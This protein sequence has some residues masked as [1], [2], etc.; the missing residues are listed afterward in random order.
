MAFELKNVVPWGRN[1]KEY[2]SMFKLTDADLNKRMISI[3][4]GPA[5]FNHEMTRLSKSV[6]SLDPIYQF[7]ESELTQR[8]EETKDIV[9]EQMSKNK[10]N[11]IWTNFK[12]IEELE[13]VRLSAMNDFLKDFEI[14]KKEKRYVT[15]SM[16]EKTSFPDL[17][18]ELGLSS[19]F[20]VLYSQL[21]LEFHIQSINEMLRIAKEIRIFPLL[22]LDAKKSE[23]VDDLIAH[24]QTDY[25]VQI[26]KVDYEFQKNG[27]E[28]LTIKRK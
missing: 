6:V 7:T 13:S 18:F 25:I 26:E 11:F 22:N 5:S 14:G 3:G 23:L 19:H 12:D 4:D 15:H 27:N 1:L 16:P 28:M 21:G 10:D 8:I 24:F 9:I 17:T 20:L 2:K